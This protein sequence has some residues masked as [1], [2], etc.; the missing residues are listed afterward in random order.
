MR[1][2]GGFRSVLA[3]LATG[4]VAG[5]LLSGCGDDDGT[6][7]I[8][9]SAGPL[10]FVR[11]DSSVVRFSK[12]ATLY[13][14]CGDWS[15]GEIVVPALHVWFGTSGSAGL[16]WWLRAVVGDIELDAPLAFPNYFVWN[17]PD[18]VHIFLYDPPNELATDTEESGGTITFHQLP[19]PG[20]GTVDFSIDA[21]L[22][23]E[24]GDMPPV[25]V[26][27]RFTK[28]IT[29]TPPWGLRL[30]VIVGPARK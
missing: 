28:Q 11:E 16:Y 4:A 17:Q 15:P 14:W 20:D 25:S 9:G 27:G 18:S 13:I 7:P 23:S 12:S 22:G 24:Y 30:P 26:Q 10:E 6:G 19:C 21:I 1:L 29:T 2:R 8:G 3:A 5:F